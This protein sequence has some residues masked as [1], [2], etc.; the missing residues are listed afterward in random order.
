[1]IQSTL[2]SFYLQ[3]SFLIK[4]EIKSAEA[5]QGIFEQALASTERRLEKQHQMTSWLL[6]KKPVFEMVQNDLV[7]KSAKQFLDRLG[8]EAK[9]LEAKEKIAFHLDLA[10]DEINPSYLQDFYDL[11]SKIEKV[12][13]VVA[14]CF[15]H[16]QDPIPS[17]TRALA[18]KI[19]SGQ[20]EAVEVDETLI[21]QTRHSKVSKLLFLGDKVIKKSYLGQQSLLMQQKEVQFLLKFQHPQIPRL[22]H[23]TEGHVYMTLIEGEALCD[24]NL[25][26]NQFFSLF[27]SLASLLQTLHTFGFSHGDLFDANVLVSL[28][29]SMPYLI[30]FADSEENDKETIYA[31][32]S[33]FSDLLCDY[34]DQIKGE[35]SKEL[36]QDLQSLS[37]YCKMN[38]KDEELFSY[39]I[40]S[41]N[42]TR[43]IH[44]EEIRMKRSRTDESSS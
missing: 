3:S 21:S 12:H 23:T 40:A 41:L 30:D 35:I 24:I 20:L 16:F 29:D 6:E 17:S 28:E 8:L 11:Y 2:N 15:E 14:F 9:K 7:K 27:T 26:I 1:M 5:M 13:Q 38:K 39:I 18:N 34:S 33:C 36:F 42:E 4:Q 22:L 43:E 25:N 10:I 44:E 31:D 19:L 32:I 37:R